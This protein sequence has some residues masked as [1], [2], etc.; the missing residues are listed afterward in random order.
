MQTHRALGLAGAFRT[1]AGGEATGMKRRLGL[2]PPGFFFKTPGEGRGPACAPTQ[3]FLDLS[4]GGQA[5]MTG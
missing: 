5:L 3:T 2:P 1:E 4:G